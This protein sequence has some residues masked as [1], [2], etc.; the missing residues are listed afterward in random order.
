MPYA[1]EAFRTLGN[2]AILSPKDITPQQVRDTD[3][4]LI[5]S[6]TV[7]DRAL[8]KGSRVKFVGTATIGTDHMDLDYFEQAGIAWCA[9]PGCN[10]NSVSEYITAALLCLG[11]RHNFSLDG[12]TAGIIGVGNVGSLVVRKAEA[13]GLRVLQNDPPKLEAT[14]DAVFQPLDR[15]LEASDI[16][17]LHTPLTKKGK[18]PTFHMVDDSFFKQLKPGCVLLNSARGAVV[19]SDAMLAAM[20]NG[21]VAHGVLDTWE[22]EPAF[23]TDVLK[24]MDLGTP[25][26]AGHSFEGK[27]MGTV[28]V[29]RE[30]CR[31]LGV[32]HSWT[33]DSLLPEPVVPEINLNASGRDDETVLRDLVRCVYDIEADDHN[34]RKA[35]VDNDKQRQ[36][37]F[38]QLRNNYPVRREFRFTRV[39]LQNSHP[40]LDKKV[41]GLG[42]TVQP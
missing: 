10:A 16:I 25:H 24:R 34:L 27:V 35:A 36:E 19:D 11:E 21:I 20:D 1:E 6:T 12:K 29:F 7:V 9:A 13:L 5:R 40:G 14:G 42:F 33:P 41:R 17:T 39:T 22:G 32:T 8:L 38:E 15:I 26:V 30:A 23:R 28:M 4:L 37:R 31:F 3:L 18:Y 2:V